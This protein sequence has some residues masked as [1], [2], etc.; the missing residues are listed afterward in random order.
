M[1]VIAILEKVMYIKTKDFLSF[2][3]Q[4]LFLHLNQCPDLQKYQQPLV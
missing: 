3:K 4:T 1:A 2:L